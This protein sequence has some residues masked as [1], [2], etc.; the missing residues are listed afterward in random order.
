MAKN[1]PNQEDDQ[2]IKIES[3][4]DHPSGIDKGS[5]RTIDRKNE[6]MKNIDPP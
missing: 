1:E 4:D 2:E 6:S 3:R 5:L